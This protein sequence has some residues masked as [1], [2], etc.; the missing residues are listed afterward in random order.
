MGTGLL[1]FFALEAGEYTEQLDGA[2][3][4]AAGKVP[5]L[6]VFTRNARALRGSATMARVDGIAR[7]ATGL[8]R[9]GRGLRDGSLQ[10]TPQLRGAIIAAIDDVKILVRGARTWGKAE[11][12]RA[13]ARAA[14]LDALAPAFS[15]RSVVTPML[16]IGSGLWLAS[17]TADIAAAL[18][19][20]VEQT[21]T[22][23]ALADTVKR[24]RS[25][26]GIAALAD[27]P[28]IKDVI[29]TVDD[30]AKMLELGAAPTD[31]HRYVFRTASDVLREASE[32]VQA[33]KKPGTT[34]GTVAAFTAAAAL[35]VADTEDKDYVVPISALFPDGAGDNVV[36]A[37]PHPPTTPQE[38]FRMEVVSQAEH[39]RRLI[40]DARS[41]GEG[42]TRQR[43]ANDLRAAT[44][45]LQRAAESF[46]ETATAHAVQG[47]VAPAAALETMALDALDRIADSLAAGRTVGTTSPSAP[48][49]VITPAVPRPEPRPE[50]PA[51]VATP[52]PAATLT[53][54]TPTP[55]ATPTVPTR[56]PS[57]PYAGSAAVSRATGAIV[58]PAPT[59]ATL[60]HALESGLSGLAR[61]A[62]EPM[63]EPANVDEDDGVVPIQDLVYR[64]KA[65]LARAIAVG[66]AIKAGAAPADHDTLAELFDLL[67]LATT[68]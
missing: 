56:R 8:E 47:L 52:V 14:E 30:V 9:L 64:G 45:A 19:R 49:P 38:R 68:E 66:E 37:A 65:A 35:L 32:A 28:P 23:E 59:G 26:R 46:G 15:R 61:L 5:D 48:T 17:E 67:E 3:A 50:S 55:A 7:V 2:L 20:W 29:D 31:A 43:A 33:G 41:A 6:D 1:D 24:V 44:R 62:D 12:E 58:M 39:L 16:A 11:D 10:W 40:A 42:P 54:A 51:P 25:L 22:V 13:A 57:T 63:A 21:G 4:R 53:P 18:R 60:R 36:H 27:L 34:T